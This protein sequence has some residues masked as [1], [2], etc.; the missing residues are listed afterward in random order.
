M[1]Y[2]QENYTLKQENSRLHGQL[3]LLQTKIADAEERYQHA[4]NLYEQTLHKYEILHKE[5]EKIAHILHEKIGRE[6][7]K[8]HAK[9]HNKDDDEHNDEH[10]RHHVSHLSYYT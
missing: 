9:H 1:E 10:H 3:Q 4:M 6:H 5:H 2:Q 8:K 7:D